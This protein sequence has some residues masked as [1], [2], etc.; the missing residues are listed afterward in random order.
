MVRSLLSARRSGS[1]PGRRAGRLALLALL[2]ALSAPPAGLSAAD[3]M[4]EVK[5]LYATAAYEDTLALLSR[6]EAAGDADVRDGV[7]EYRALCL[8][9]LGRDRDAE[10]AMEALATRHPL[11]LEQLDQR[12]PRFVS[13][14]QQVR[15][16]LVPTLATTAY[17]SGK[18]AYDS[19]AFPEAAAQFREA[20][21]LL[22]SLEASQPSELA[23]LAS[24][25]LALAEK[26]VAPA[27]TPAPIPAPAAAA[28][29]A[30]VTAP[31]NTPTE[32]AGRSEGSAPPTEVTP[33]PMAPTPTAA[34]AVD[35]AAVD[36]A[37]VV[38]VTEVE[39]PPSDPSP[40]PEPAQFTP[41]PRLYTAADPDVT[42]PVVI[43]QRLPR[44]M[45][46]NEMLRRRTFSGRVQ[47]IVGADGRVMDA[48]IIQP[49]FSF[50]D[51]EVLRA[52]RQWRYQPAT[53][54]GY[55]VQY[56][57]TVDYVISG[58]QGSAR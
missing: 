6:I 43:D 30:P 51:E 19:G 23:L 55:P 12:A 57:R 49:S 47:I 21:A 3:P 5:S 15:V 2:A 27:P 20:V 40:R 35:A 54:R 37:T 4:A 13:L 53:K 17:T 52:T 33:T 9:A 31:V 7:D 45:P 26:S 18:R 38:E 25:F 8:M 58:Q 16:R 11:T 22:E 39:A 56:R 28:A 34:T 41:V 44:W 24:G 50:Y 48:E 14:Y 10:K 36:V 42:A 46:P 32:L 29:T 1:L